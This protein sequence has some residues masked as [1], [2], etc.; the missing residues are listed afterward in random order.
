MSDTP[1]AI[2]R[3]RTATSSDRDAIHEVHWSAFAEDDREIVARLAVDLLSEETTP[4]TLSLVAV[5][6]GI[7]AG[8]VAFT[9][10]TAEGIEDFRGYILAPLAVRPD[11]QRR[12]IGTLLV[13]SAIR[14]L[15][16]MG[17]DL[18]LVYG[19]PEY[20]GRFGFSADVAESC[21]PPYELE[22]PSG[23]QGIVLSERGIPES[24]FTLDCVAS[25]RDPALW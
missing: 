22:Y 2:M 3:I 15:S 19:D 10:A 21:V 23:W 25:L 5:T 14:Q 6:E 13:E 4:P 1:G 20:Y 18:L 8:H 7:V 12:H 9:P 16:G 17:T 11:H 24:P